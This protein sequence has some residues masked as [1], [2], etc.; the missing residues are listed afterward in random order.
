MA[1]GLFSIILISRQLAI[2]V[3]V[4]FVFF[5]FSLYHKNTKNIILSSLSDLTIVSDREW[6]DNLFIVLVAR[7]LFVCVG[8]RNLHDIFCPTLPRERGPYW[9]L[10]DIK[11]SF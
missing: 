2:F 9:K 6:I 5:T 7:F 1:P 10:R 3:A 8:T 4:Y 11:A